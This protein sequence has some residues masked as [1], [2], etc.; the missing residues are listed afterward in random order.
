MSCNPKK[1]YC[2][3]CSIDNLNPKINISSSEYSDLDDVASAF[4][5][6]MITKSLNV[7]S[8]NIDTP[9][10]SKKSNPIPPETNTSTYLESNI[11]KSTDTKDLFNQSQTCFS[12]YGIQG[13]AHFQKCIEEV[14]TE[15]NKCTILNQQYSRSK[16][17]ILASNKIETLQTLQTELNTSLQ[18]SEKMNMLI[19]NT[20]K[21]L[22]DQCQDISKC[23]AELKDKVLNYSK[24]QTIE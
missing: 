15:I 10:P 13:Y 20:V 19:R 7:K 1:F 4:C 11:D 8:P 9:G 16:V 14:W 12:E 17:N 23:I 24:N 18:K 21:A 5:D 2:I 6:F 3:S 22:Q